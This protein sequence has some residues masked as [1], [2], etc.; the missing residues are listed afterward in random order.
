[1]DEVI[2]QNRDKIINYF[3]NIFIEKVSKNLSYYENL[4][5]NNYF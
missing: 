2:E 4:I 5:Y 1:M 3:K